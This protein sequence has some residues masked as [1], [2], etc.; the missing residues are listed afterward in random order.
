MAGPYRDAHTAALEH[1]ARLER[2]IDA[3]RIQGPRPSVR[4]GRNRRRILVGVL[5]LVTT[6]AI[7][8]RQEYDVPTA[9]DSPTWGNCIVQAEPEGVARALRR[10]VIEPRALGAMRGELEEL[11][12]ICEEQHDGR[13]AARV[14]RILAGDVEHDG[15][16]P[17]GGLGRLPERTSR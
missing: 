1:I 9:H 3:L 11:R 14:A 17:G 6:I 7:I 5:S 8:P 4:R 2:E 10:A 13:C 12:A 15:L 16:A